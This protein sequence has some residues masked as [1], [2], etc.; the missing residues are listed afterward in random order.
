MLAPGGG[1]RPH[2]GLHDTVEVYV[3]LAGFGVTFR[4]GLRHILKAK[5]PQL[6]RIGNERSSVHIALASAEFGVGNHPAVRCAVDA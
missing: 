1:A 2:A 6:L 5:A 4:G 3:P